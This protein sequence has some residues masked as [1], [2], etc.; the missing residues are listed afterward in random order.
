MLVIQKLEAVEIKIENINTKVRINT[1]LSDSLLHFLEIIENGYFPL[2]SSPQNQ[3]NWTDIAIK[4]VNTLINTFLSDIQ[5]ME[6][7]MEGHT[8][9][10]IPPDLTNLTSPDQI[11]ERLHLFESS[12]ITW[13][14]NVMN[15][16]QNK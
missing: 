15:N 1:I 8:Y 11:K 12:I 10:P 6:G 16:R 14:S 4:E 13:V 7:K 3:E 2:L 9:L 5:I